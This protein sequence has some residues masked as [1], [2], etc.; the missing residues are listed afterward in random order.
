[1]AIRCLIVDP[2]HENI[3]PLLHNIGVEYDYEP[4]INRN[5]IIACISKY[6]GLII[7]SKTRVDEG[8]IAHSNLKFVARAGAGI[9]NLDEA[10]LKK[11]NI[12]IINAP[13]GNRDAVGEHTVGII[14]NLLHN[15]SKGHN[16]I[17]AN[18][19]LRDRIEAG[20]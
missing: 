3:A 6:D 5:E 12:A 8:L 15:I 17:M 14:L 4:N 13:E 18:Q 20:N 11:E 1:M 7:R 19:W 9:D 2:L 16:E 10:F